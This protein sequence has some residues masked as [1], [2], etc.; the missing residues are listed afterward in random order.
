ML[1]SAAEVMEYNYGIEETGNGYIFF[2]IVLLIAIL[3][4]QKP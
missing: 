3:C 1:L 2:A 4:L